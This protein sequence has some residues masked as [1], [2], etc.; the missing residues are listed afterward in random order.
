ME[1]AIK[2]FQ[3]DRFT[4]IYLMEVGSIVVRFCSNLI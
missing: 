1:A 4:L 3:A 2:I